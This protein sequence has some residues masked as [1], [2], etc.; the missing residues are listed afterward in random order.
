MKH[1]ILDFGR[2]DSQKLAQNIQ[3]GQKIAQHYAKTSDKLQAH[4][5]DTIFANWAAQP[6]EKSFSPQQ[7]AEG[8]G[9]MFGEIL[10]SNFS[11]MWKIIEDDHGREAALVDDL[12]G[13]IV[14][15]VNSV[16]KRVEPEIINTPFF[17][18]MYAAIEQHLKSQ[19][20]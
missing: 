6:A 4:H 9:S 19:K 5:L 11:F 15:P 16:Y 1:Q 8:L 3:L 17:K 20:G 10:K 7:V 2:Q 14:F 18:E 13:S 12:T